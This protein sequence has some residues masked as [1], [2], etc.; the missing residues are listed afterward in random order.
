MS[1]NLVSVTANYIGTNLAG[2]ASLFNGSDGVSIFLASGNHIGGSD[3]ADGNLISG[4]FFCGVYMD[5]ASGNLVDGNLIGLNAAGTASLGNGLAG[6]CIFNSDGNQIG[7]LA[8]PFTGAGGRRGPA[9]VPYPTQFIAGNHGHGILLANSNSNW[10]GLSTA[11]GIAP[12]GTALGN[13]FHGV[14]VSGSSINQIYPFAANYNGLDGVSVTGESSTRN[15]ITPKWVYGN[16]GLP[17][18]LGNDGHTPN[19][20]GDGDTGPNTLL[21]Y[22]VITSA[23]GAPL[24]VQGTAC[25]NCRVVVYRATGNPSRPGGGGEYLTYTSA[26]GAGHWSVSLAPWPG[27]TERDITLLAVDITGSQNASELSPRP[28]VYLPMIWR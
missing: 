28:I 24:L 8:T 17:I 20:P 19:D 5:H 22:P 16:G 13:W 10:V 3:P 2:T 9:G 18:D 21:N 4:N 23:G 25:A 11:I 15:A 7:D 26:D 6:M 14:L 12:S 1:S 27:L